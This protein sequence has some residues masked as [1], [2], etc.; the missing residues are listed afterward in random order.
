MG[1]TET[2]VVRL[3]PRLLVSD[4]FKTWGVPEETRFTNFSLKFSFVVP[5]EAAVNFRRNG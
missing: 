3:G 2:V 5:E 4:D 1:H